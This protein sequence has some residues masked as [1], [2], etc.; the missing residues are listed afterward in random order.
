MTLNLILPVAEI[1]QIIHT[2]VWNTVLVKADI[3]S[4]CTTYLSSTVFCRHE[5]NSYDN[6]YNRDLD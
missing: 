3:P 6:P 2:Y 4:V 5:R 1:A